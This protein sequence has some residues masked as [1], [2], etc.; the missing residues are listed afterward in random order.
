MGISAVVLTKDESTNIIKCLETLA[1][2]NEII[3]ID[4]GS[5]DDTIIAAKSVGACV[6]K[7]NLNGDFAEVRN[8]AL[9][10]AK[11]KW[12]LYID[13]DERVSRELAAEI[14]QFVNDPIL[15]FKG[16]YLRRIDEMWGRQLLHGEPGRVKL[17]RLA[18]KGAGKWE[19]KVHEIWKING[20]TYELKTPLLHYPH[21]TLFKFIEHVNVFST[22]HAKANQLEG[23]KS[24]LF[25]IMF[26]P[27]FKL[28]EGWIFKKGFK[29]GIQGFI[30]ACLMSF[31]SFLS[32]GKLWL[33]QKKNNY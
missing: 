29:D 28:I 21:S 23:K 32:W 25:K 22:L 6:I 4:T 13:A 24:S 33:L 19:R 31:H 16:Y 18:R 17:L 15:N 9:T 8:Y 3:V 5:L 26:Y 12:V 14:V 11:E 30:V 20:T 27:P 1:F 7:K 2:C 10:K